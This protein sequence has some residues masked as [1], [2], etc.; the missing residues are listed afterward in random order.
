MSYE[1]PCLG[2]FYLL[3]Q[4][5]KCGSVHR[6]AFSQGRGVG[7]LD[8]A[9]LLTLQLTVVLMVPCFIFQ[10]HAFFLETGLLER[11]NVRDIRAA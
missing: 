4:S 1:R 11:G 7:M 2:L 10:V 5:T 6:D 3:L 8:E 9:C